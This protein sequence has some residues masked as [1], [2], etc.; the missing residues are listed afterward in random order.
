MKQTVKKT[1]TKYKYKSPCDSC[2][3]AKLPTSTLHM[4]NLLEYQA[5]MVHFLDDQ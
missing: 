4:H 1:Q 2:K 5:G 3:T